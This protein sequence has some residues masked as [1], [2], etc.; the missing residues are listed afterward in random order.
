MRV[1]T[2]ENGVVTSAEPESA[3]TSKY[4]MNLALQA[5]RRWRFKPAQVEGRAVSGEW[6]LRFHFE[7]TETTVTVVEAVH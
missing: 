5:A 7:P 3:V 1:N 4:F 2:D 6:V